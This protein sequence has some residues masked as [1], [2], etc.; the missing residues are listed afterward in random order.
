MLDAKTYRAALKGG[1]LPLQ[2]NEV[3]IMSFHYAN[4]LRDELKAL[5]WDMVV[6]D[7]A[8]RLRSA[9]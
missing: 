4:R 9:Y 7:E 5:A 3:V 1:L 6:I 2:E 8:H